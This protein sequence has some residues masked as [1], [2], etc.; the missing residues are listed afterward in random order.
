[1]MAKK[2][3]TTAKYLENPELVMLK[4]LRNLRS[5]AEMPGKDNK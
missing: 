4:V 1:M 3:V 2:M 5:V